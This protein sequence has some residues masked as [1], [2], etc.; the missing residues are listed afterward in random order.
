MIDEKYHIDDIDDI[1]NVEKPSLGKIEIKK[2][3][4]IKSRVI[5]ESSNT[6]FNSTEAKDEAEEKQEEQ[7]EKKED[8]SV[9]EDVKLNL[10]VRIFVSRYKK[11]PNTVKATIVGFILSLMIL[12]IGLSKTLLIA[13]IVFISNIIGQLMDQNPTLLYIIDDIR[14]RFR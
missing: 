11:T 8:D 1:N 2:D 5:Y 7:E 9:S 13:V 14:K 6:S 12:F 4:V 10:F 3:P